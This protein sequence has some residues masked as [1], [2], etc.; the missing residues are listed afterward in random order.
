MT[1]TFQQK[2][3]RLTGLPAV[4]QTLGEPGQ[5]VEHIA[6]EHIHHPDGGINERRSFI[7]TFAS[8]LATQRSRR[9]GI[10]PNKIKSEIFGSMM[11]YAQSL[12]N[13]FQHSP[14]T[15]VEIK[16]RVGMWRGVLRIEG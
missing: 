4:V 1:G 2:P 11:Q 8:G 3:E 12:E 10:P 5:P 9:T 7:N 15:V 16:R 13:E 14:D 6:F